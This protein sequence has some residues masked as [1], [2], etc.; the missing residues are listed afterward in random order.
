MVTLIISDVIGDP[1]DVIASGPTVN[2]ESVPEQAMEILDRL[3]PVSDLIPESVT[4][5]LRRKS[6]QRQVAPA[7]D[8]VRFQNVI[9]GSNQIAV[10][11]AADR[12][13]RLGFHVEVESGVGGVAADLGRALAARCCAIR[14][15]SRAVPVC[16]I[17][18]GEP[19]VRLADTDVPRKGGRNQE[20]VLAACGQ[21]REDDAPG[22]VILSGGTDG[23][24]G[25]TDAAGAWLDVEVLRRMRSLELVPES[26][27]A[28][29]NSYAFFQ[30]T[31]G[32]LLTGPTHTNVMDLRVALIDSGRISDG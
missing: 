22:I 2:D 27:L 10:E 20:L 19:V 23:E 15:A 16:L 14:G 21:L 7:I 25:P 32:L 28:I 24:D 8:P 1:L 11:A 6:E 30:Q 18:G 31:G 12:A 4:M 9:L 17:S 29:N 3:V 26:F 13:R 5:A